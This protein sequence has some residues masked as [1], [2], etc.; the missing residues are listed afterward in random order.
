M[1]NVYNDYEIENDT[2]ESVEEMNPTPQFQKPEPVKKRRVEYDKKGRVRKDNSMG[3]LK[4]VALI[5]FITLVC[6]YAFHACG[7]DIFGVR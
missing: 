7:A 3:V 1:K 4:G 5:L 2:V 6:W